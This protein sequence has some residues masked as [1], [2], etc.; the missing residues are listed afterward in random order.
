MEREG[1]SN[2]SIFLLDIAALIIT[3]ATQAILRYYLRALLLLFKGDRA[4][5]VYINEYDAEGFALLM[6]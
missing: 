2:S 4:S 6:K 1:F 3:G 5:L